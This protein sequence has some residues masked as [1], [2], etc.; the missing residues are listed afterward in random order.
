MKKMRGLNE[1]KKG[2]RCKIGHTC[3]ES[4]ERKLIKEEK[5]NREE[6]YLV[7]GVAQ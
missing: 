3:E 1:G 7:L 4:V 5:E 2:L 6:K